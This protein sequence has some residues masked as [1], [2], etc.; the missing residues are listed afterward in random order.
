[1]SIDIYSVYIAMSATVARAEA[2]LQ[3]ALDAYNADPTEQNLM[4][5]QM[6]LEQWSVVTQAESNTLKTISTGISATVQNLR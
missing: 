1:M 3:A 5:L 2:D 4:T 6:R